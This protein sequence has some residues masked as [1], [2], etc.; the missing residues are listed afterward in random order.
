M[1]R[2]LTG[3]SPYPI[4]ALVSAKTLT[5]KLGEIIF[6]EGDES[7]EAYLIKSGAVS[8]MI[9]T[10]RGQKPVAHLHAG[11]I[12]GEMGIVDDQPR[13]A[14]ARALEDVEL[15]VI[16]EDSLEDFLLEDRVRFRTYLSTM[17]ERLRATDSMLQLA[18]R[19]EMNRTQS[20]QTGSDSLTPSL[21]SALSVDIHKEDD[22]GPAVG[23]TPIGQVTISG[24]GIPE[25]EIRRFPFRIGREPRHGKAGPFI[26]SDLTILDQEPFQISRYHCSIEHQDDHLAVR[27]RGSTNG[28]I[29]NGKQLGVRHGTTAAQL[30]T[31]ENEIILG[32]PASPHHLKVVVS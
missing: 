2:G 9:R 7:T 22:S 12:F 25:Q 20:Q 27:D 14:T 21:E 11:E 17:I 30:H 1:A 10:P 5:F 3:A 4:T 18:I 23:S 24:D 31:G 28:T 26:R 32:G 15:V 16:S 13:S 19:K 29:V 6:R 8:I